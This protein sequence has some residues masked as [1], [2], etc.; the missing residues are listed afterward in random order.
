MFKDII[1]EADELYAL[2]GGPSKLVQN[3]VIN[4]LDEHCK[5]FIRKCPFLLVAT[6]DGNGNLDVSPRGDQA[7]FVRVLNE[8]Y[9]LIPE[10][11]GNKRMDTLYNLI[12]YPGAGLLFMI[13]GLG[14][15]LR[16]NGKAY[17]VKDSELLKDMDVNGQT[18]VLGIG[19]EVEEAFIHCAKAFIRS[20]LWNS[21]T[22]PDKKSLPSAAKILAAHANQPLISE[23]EIE[24]QLKEGYTSRLY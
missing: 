11:K 21:T 20:E 18:P 1:T 8:K 17:V 13:P 12:R 6:S 9:L 15:T 7:G 5:N 19:I 23:E 24:V 4:R 3:K 10:R 22:W 16:V 14:E 2:V